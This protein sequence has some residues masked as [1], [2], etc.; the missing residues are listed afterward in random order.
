MNKVVEVKLGNAIHKLSS[1]EPERLQEILQNLSDNYS[2]I[3]QQAGGKLQS[4]KLMLLLAVRLQEQVD[5]L[6]KELEEL[7]SNNFIHQDDAHGEM[8]EAIEE[9][10]KYVDGLAKEHI[11]N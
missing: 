9:I 10:I 3:M 8:V 5:A 2:H 1:D 4:A 6:T 7:R 11:V